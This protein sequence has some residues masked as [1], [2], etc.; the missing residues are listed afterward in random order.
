[1]KKTTL[2][3]LSAL[4]AAL[5]LVG[6]LAACSSDATSDSETTTAG[7]GDVTT[8]AVETETGREGAKSDLP[9]DLDFGGESIRL[10]YLGNNATKL[11]EAEGEANSG[12]KVYDSLYQANMRVAEDLNINFEFRPTGTAHNDFM[13]AVRKT[14]LAQA[15][16]YDI[17][18]GSQWL[19]I[20][21]SMDGLYLDLSDA[22]YLDFDKPWWDQTYIDMLSPDGETK[23]FLTGDISLNR[24]RQM[25][26]MYFNK[27]LYTS[28]I[29][30]PDDMYQTVLD[31]TWDLDMLMELVSD[32]YLDLNGDQTADE[33]DQYGINLMGQG[34]SP[35]DHYTFSAG[36]KYSERDS[37]GLPVVVTDQTRNSL[38]AEKL[39]K[40]FFETQGVY[41]YANVQGSSTP[42]MD[43][44]MIDNFSNDRALFY[45]NRLYTSEL[46]RDMESDFGIIPYPKLDETQETYLALVHD[47]V[48]LWCIPTTCTKSD[49]VTA[50]LEALACEKY[51]SVTLTYYETALKNKYIR[52]TNYSQ[53][54]DII[55]ENVTSDFIYMY[56]YA[57]NNAGSLGTLT[58]QLVTD[59]SLG[60]AS[61]YAKIESAV[62]TTLASMIK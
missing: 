27:E 33:F 8:E 26:A 60:Y 2:R 39:Q 16:E 22:K 51:R 57:F 1:M 31:G 23:Y 32:V 50:V 53:I 48:F 15:D 30:D 7:G 40:L 47:G 44:R 28:L 17:V 46:L 5:T 45:G 52:D 24:L 61:E 11:L 35:I 62:E 21:Q 4:L 59:K 29:G 56:N 19:V 14:I 34:F 6:T 9:D 3:R 43:E 12:D 38:V 55:R 58:R 36:M 37:D 13:E 10:A 54:I 18:A 42:I 25:S 20:P 41:Y 49:T